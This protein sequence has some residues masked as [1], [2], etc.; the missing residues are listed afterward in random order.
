MMRLEQI[1]QARYAGGLAVQ[2]DAIRAQLEQT[3]MRTELIAIDNEKRQ[4]RARLTR[5]TRGGGGVVL[6]L[7]DVTDL[8]RAQRVFAWGEMARQVAHEIKNPLTPI[9][10]G[11]QHLRRARAD[12]RDDFDVIL[13]RNVTRILEEIDRLDEIARSFSKFG[14]A[15]GERIPGVATDIAAVVRDV[16]ALERLGDSGVEWVVEGDATPVFAISRADE[17]REVLLN[18]LE[19]A[20]HANATRVV[21]TVVAGDP[22]GVGEGVAIVVMDNGDGI[23]R[24]VLPR[25]FE[26]HFSTRTSGSGL[27]LAISKRLVD[28]WGGAIHLAPATPHGTIVRVTLVPAPPP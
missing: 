20:R 26:P 22:R 11:V 13:E 24:E 8:A 1:A 3:A 5:L 4:L 10:L 19:N 23:D 14:T 21:A 18:I 9:R 17:L 7:D 2:Q 28:S 6:T 25:V 12:R 15:P 27:G 16:V